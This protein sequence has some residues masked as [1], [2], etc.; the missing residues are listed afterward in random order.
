MLN[1]KPYVDDFAKELLNR[2]CDMLK[3]RKIN[4]E[5]FLT[6]VERI[7]SSNDAY[8]NDYEDE[9]FIMEEMIETFR[10]LEAQK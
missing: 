1:R 8:Y 6:A 10:S 9:V 3:D 4:N 2:A 5:N 7:N